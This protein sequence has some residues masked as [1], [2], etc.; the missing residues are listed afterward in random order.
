MSLS[1]S[2][3]YSDS[4]NNPSGPWNAQGVQEISFGI[5]E[6]INGKNFFVK[7]IVVVE[8]NGVFKARNEYNST[9]DWNWSANKL[10]FTLKG[11][12]IQDQA[13]Y[14]VNVELGLTQKYLQH[15]VKVYTGASYTGQDNNSTVRNGKKT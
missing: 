5:W 6:P 2:F 11:F 14:G 1:W 7:K 13:T 3:A 9:I 8:S 4:V 10:T 15:T 12:K